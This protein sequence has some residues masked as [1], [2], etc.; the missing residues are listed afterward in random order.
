VKVVQEIAQSADGE[1][2]VSEEIPLAPGATD[3]ARVAYAGFASDKLPPADVVMR[4]LVL[5]DGK[6]VGRAVRTHRKTR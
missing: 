5:V 2:L 3:D 1:A 4:A 6:L